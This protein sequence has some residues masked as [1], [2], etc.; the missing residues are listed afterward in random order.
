MKPEVLHEIQNVCSALVL[1]GLRKNPYP[2]VN[3]RQELKWQRARRREILGFIRKHYG[4]RAAETAANFPMF[5]E[6]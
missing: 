2:M 4:Q 3:P 6:H 5:T 1:A